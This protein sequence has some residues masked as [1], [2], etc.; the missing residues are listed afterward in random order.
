MLEDPAAVLGMDLSGID[1]PPLA[2]PDLVGVTDPQVG[3]RLQRGQL[4]FEFAR[5]PFV[6]GVQ[7]RYPLT[8]GGLDSP[9]PSRT[10]ASVLLAQKADSW[11]PGLHQLSGGVGRSVVD[12]DH[13]CRQACLFDHRIEGARQYRRPIESRDDHADFTGSDSHEPILAIFFQPPIEPVQYG[14]VPQDAV[15]GPQHPVVL[16]GK[17]Q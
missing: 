14:L 7:K 12:D 6:V 10:D 15:G 9:I 17:V 13:F 8:P 3:L 4:P 5:P 1:A 11:K 16:I 2:N